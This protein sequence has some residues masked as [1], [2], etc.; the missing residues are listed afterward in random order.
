MILINSKLGYNVEDQKCKII[1][2][3]VN[4]VVFGNSFY[5]VASC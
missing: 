1:F 3:T 2:V 5:M 4:F